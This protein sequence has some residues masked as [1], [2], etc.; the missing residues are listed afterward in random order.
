MEDVKTVTSHMDPNQKLTTEMCPKNDAERSQVEDI[1][2]HSLI[3]SL[4][5]LSV[6]TRPDITHSVN[7]LSQFNN[8]P[9]KLHWQAA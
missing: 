8:N 6:A 7:F 4:M 2:Y 5:Y 1:P 9:G 3:G